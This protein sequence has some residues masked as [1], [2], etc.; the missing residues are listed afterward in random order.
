MRFSRENR[1]TLFLE[2]LEHIPKSKEAAA[3]RYRLLEPVESGA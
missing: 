3:H 1:L 2:L